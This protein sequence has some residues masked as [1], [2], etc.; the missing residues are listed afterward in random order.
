MIDDG[1]TAQMLAERHP[2]KQDILGN[3]AKC[4]GLTTSA[5]TPVSSTSKSPF[6]DRLCDERP[7]HIIIDL[8]TMKQLQKQYNTVVEQNKD[9][10]HFSCVQSISSSF[11]NVSLHWST[12]RNSDTSL[13]DKQSSWQVIRFTGKHLER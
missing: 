5:K 1:I 3:I 11:I 2:L 6:L 4:R 7:S 12:I 10:R 9:S 13:V 8:S